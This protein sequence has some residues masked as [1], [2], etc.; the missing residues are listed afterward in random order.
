MGSRRRVALAT[1]L[2]LAAL[3][4]T[5]CT[6]EGAADAPPGS[7]SPS[8]G[9]GEP[10]GDTGTAPATPSPA[11]V[12]PDPPRGPDT[13]A[14]RRQ[15][16][17]YVLQAWVYALGTND[18]EPLTS[19]GRQDRCGGCRALEKELAKRAEQRWS[20]ALPGVAVSDSRQ[21]RTRGSTRVTLEVDIP[22]GTTRFDD[23][24]FRS[25]TPAHPGTRF[26]VEVGR[27][28]NRFVLVSFG[29]S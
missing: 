18:P 16:A 26:V 3:A 6:D 25:S 15:F 21:S 11:A 4:L 20:V 1:P 2:V 17:R 27:A 24:R 10:T 5:A 8:G 29:V 12:V 7:P 22:A 28:R 14:G 19:V 9:T 13:P 23:G